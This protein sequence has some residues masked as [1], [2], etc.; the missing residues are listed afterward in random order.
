ML[1]HNAHT[2]CDKE[3]QPL[4]NAQMLER[5]PSLL[6]RARPY[7]IAVVV[8]TVVAASISCC[9]LLS[10]AELELQQTPVT[11]VP[12]IVLQVR[13]TVPPTKKKC[14][15]RVEAQ[16]ALAA[17]DSQAA[18]SQ[19]GGVPASSPVAVNIPPPQHEVIV[20]Q[21]PVSINPIS[22]ECVGHAPEKVTYVAH[23]NTMAGNVTYTHTDPQQPFLY[24]DPSVPGVSNVTCNSTYILIQSANVSATLPFFHVGAHVLIPLSYPSCGQQGLLNGTLQ[25]LPGYRIVQSAS[26]LS[27][28]NGILK[29]DTTTDDL[30]ANVDISIF[31]A[32]MPP[33]ATA[34]ARRDI[35]F[36]NGHE[37]QFDRHLHWGKDFAW[38]KDFQGGSVSAGVGVEFDLDAKMDYNVNWSVHIKLGFFK[39][40]YEYTL[41]GNGELSITPQM[42]LTGNVTIKAGTTQYTPVAPVFTLWGLVSAGVYG[43]IEIGVELDIRGKFTIA[44]PI[45]IKHQPWTY[46][47]KKGRQPIQTGGAIEYEVDLDYSVAGT[48]IPTLSIM[49]GVGLGISIGPKPILGLEVGF[50]SRFSDILAMYIPV[51]DN[52]FL[53]NTVTYEGDL[54]VTGVAGFPQSADSLMKKWTIYKQALVPTKVLDQR[55]L[56]E[57]ASGPWAKGHVLLTKGTLP[58]A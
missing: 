18:S 30:L 45:I 16:S 26:V 53:S 20:G 46:N 55:C 1:A 14:A 56:V 22:F 38:S 12:P 42:D 34:S 24:L 47:G 17:S 33:N 7:I 27:A 11:P 19:S 28:A 36:A 43:S 2:D 44:L 10:N 41:G 29:I 8:F 50:D 40:D 4:M 32:S 52:C 31:M 5:E 3:V 49:P 15:P 21:A 9:L 25:T 35:K 13:D 54:I 57:F 51:R 58:K 37:F 23:D 48:V 39:I 6:S